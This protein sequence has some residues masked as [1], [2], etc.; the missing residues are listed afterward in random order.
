MSP[1]IHLQSIANGLCA[2]KYFN[3]N[4]TTKQMSNIAEEWSVRHFKWRRYIV[5]WTQ[6]KI[7]KSPTIVMGMDGWEV[8][9]IVDDKFKYRTVI[10]FYFSGFQRMICC[11]IVHNVRC[12][13][14]SFEKVF[15]FLSH[16]IIRFH[17]V[18]SFIHFILFI[19]VLGRTFTFARV[20]CAVWRI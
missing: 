8:L 18:S 17:R 12:A 9:Q 19:Y 2:I 4:Q 11:L 3:T 20:M 10:T 16:R 1:N 7:R 5:Q 15:Y 13:S 14:A 6:I